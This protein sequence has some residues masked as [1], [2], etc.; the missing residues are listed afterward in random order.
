MA[1]KSVDPSTDPSLILSKEDEAYPCFNKISEDYPNWGKRGEISWG[2]RKVYWIKDEERNIVAANLGVMLPQQM[3]S[4]HPWWTLV[5]IRYQQQSF[6]FVYVYALRENEDG[7]FWNLLTV[8]IDKSLLPA[9]F[10]ND[11]TFQQVLVTLI[12]EVLMAYYAFEFNPL[13]Y[14]SRVVFQNFTKLEGVEQGS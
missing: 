14:P 10:F 8:D 4:G 1:F 9:A 11:A 3:L 5:L 13:G 12:E 2:R 7:S 6:K